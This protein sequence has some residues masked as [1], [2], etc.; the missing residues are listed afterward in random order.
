[1]DFKKKLYKKKVSIYLFLNKFSKLR[2]A[3]LVLVRMHSGRILNNSD[4][5]YQ[6]N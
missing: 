3:N 5:T 1:M 4:C 6:N 2:K